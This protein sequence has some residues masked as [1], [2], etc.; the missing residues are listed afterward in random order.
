[1]GELTG[2]DTIRDLG[3]FLYTNEVRAINNYYF[4]I[5]EDVFVDSYDHVVASLVIGVVCIVIPLALV[6]MRSLYTV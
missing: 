6:V 2:N 4:D 5:H 1:M 3:I